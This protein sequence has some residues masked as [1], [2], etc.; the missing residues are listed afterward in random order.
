MEN[1]TVGNKK[2]TFLYFVS[3]LILLYLLFILCADLLYQLFTSAPHE[4]FSIGIGLYVPYDG[5][6]VLVL[7]MTVAFSFFVRRAAA[8]ISGTTRPAPGDG[9]N[10]RAPLAAALYWTAIMEMAIL[11]A[12]LTRGIG[13]CFDS[14]ISPCAGDF[15]MRTFLDVTLP[16][17]KL[18]VFSFFLIYPAVNRIVVL[19]L[20][21]VVL[22]YTSLL[23]IAPKSARSKSSILVLLNVVLLILISMILAGTDFFMGHPLLGPMPR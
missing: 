1:D 22:V 20:F 19:F 10:G 7:I 18:T 8:R 16:L 6:F 3:A 11:F 14:V 9:G 12:L 17:G 21:F 2:S 15:D 13:G 23:P 4:K 5:F